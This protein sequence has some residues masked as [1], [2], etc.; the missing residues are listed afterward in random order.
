MENFVN[1]EIQGVG[2]NYYP[3]NGQLNR[4]IKVVRDPKSFFKDMEIPC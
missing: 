1:L 2:Y 4:E 3:A